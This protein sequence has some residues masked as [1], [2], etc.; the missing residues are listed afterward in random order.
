MAENLLIYDESDPGGHLTVTSS[1]VT[2]ADLARSEDAHLSRGMGIEHFDGDYAQLQ[3]VYVDL[4]A[5][6]TLTQPALW[7]MADGAEASGQDLWDAGED[8][9]KFSVYTSSALPFILYEMD[10]PN[11]YY[12]QSPSVSYDTP[13]YLTH[14]R[15]AGLGSYGTIT[16]E[17]CSDPDRTI[18][19]TTL[20]LTCHTSLKK[21]SRVYVFQNEGNGGSQKYWGYNENFDLQEGA[22]ARRGVGRGIL[23]GVLRGI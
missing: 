22:L 13:Y 2:M 8:S 17:I 15:D 18:E 20:S 14:R 6:N 11:V 5:Q 3:T 19:I 4:A 21:Y 7:A 9:Y 1:R 10:Y 23:R 12:D 16:T